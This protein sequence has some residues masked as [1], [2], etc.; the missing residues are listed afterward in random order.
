M[1][2]PSHGFERCSKLQASLIKSLWEALQ[3]P[4]G[5]HLGP[6]L[7]AML[8]PSWAPRGSWEGVRG[9]LEGSWGHLGPKTVLKPPRSKL[10]SGFWALLGPQ[11]GPMLGPRWLPRGVEIR[12]Q[13]QHAKE[14]HLDP[15]LVPTW[16]PKRFQHEPQE[17]LGTRARGS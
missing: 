10:V 17:A 7:V 11:V 12:Y 16:L 14:L 5:T 3:G 2:R 8:G 9:L 15:N 4:L 1:A 6:L 13:H